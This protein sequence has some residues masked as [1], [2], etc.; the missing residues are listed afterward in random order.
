MLRHRVDHLNVAMPFLQL[1]LRYPKRYT[2]ERL[3]TFLRVRWF[4]HIDC[5]YSLLFAQGP[6]VPT[7]VF[8]YYT[9]TEP[10]QFDFVTLCQIHI[11]YLQEREMHFV[12]SIF[13]NRVEPFS[14]LR[15]FRLDPFS[16][17]H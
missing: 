16:Q 6:P 17:D 12:S 13:E 5:G 3:W 10:G 9:H 2:P 4:T 1:A 8:P 14:H 7:Y 11:K 15:S